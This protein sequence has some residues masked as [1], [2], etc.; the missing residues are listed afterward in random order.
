MWHSEFWPRESPKACIIT[1]NFG[2]F[3]TFLYLF[4]PSYIFSRNLPGKTN[5]TCNIAGMLDIICV[6]SKSL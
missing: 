4:G 2:Y 3:E 6:A 5:M 1:F